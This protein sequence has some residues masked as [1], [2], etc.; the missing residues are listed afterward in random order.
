MVIMHVQYTVTCVVTGDMCC[1]VVWC[2]RLAR[3]E[4]PSHRENGPVAEEVSASSPG[5]FILLYMCIDREKR[6]RAVGGV[7]CVAVVA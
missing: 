3:K 2:V 7:V 4:D 1:A 6:Q 5:V